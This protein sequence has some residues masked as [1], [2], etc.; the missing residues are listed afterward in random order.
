MKGLQ[1]L[2][3][4]HKLLEGT[5]EPPSTVFTYAML[6]EM[7]RVV[8]ICARRETDSPRAMIDAYR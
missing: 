6:A 7:E 2:S 8:A 4:L 5:Q 1:K 3:T